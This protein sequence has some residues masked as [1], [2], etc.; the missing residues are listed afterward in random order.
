MIFHSKSLR[1]SLSKIPYQSEL[2]LK[3]AS[4]ELKHATQREYNSEKFTDSQGL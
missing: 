3:I 4:P 1:L 2:P